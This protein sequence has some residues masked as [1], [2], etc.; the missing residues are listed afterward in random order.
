MK[1]YTKK[2]KYIRTTWSGKNND[3]MKLYVRIR[4]FDHNGKEQCASKHF[5]SNDYDSYKETMDAAIEW[6]DK[7]LVETRQ[8]IHTISSDTTIDNLWNDFHNVYSRAE[9][10]YKMY[11]YL[12]KN[13]IHDNFGYMAVKDVQPVDVTRSLNKCAEV[14]GDAHIGK[15]WALW[16]MLLNIPK[17]HRIYIDN[18]AE[19]AEVPKSK[20]VTKHTGTS[21]ATNET[22]FTLVD[23]LLNTNSYNKKIV[24]HAFMVMRLTGLR[25]EECFALDD[26]IFTEDKIYV[27]MALKLL[28]EGFGLG[29]LKNRTSERNVPISEECRYWLNSL[30]DL[31]DN[32][33]PFMSKK[34]KMFNIHSLSGNVAEW[35]EKIGVKC[36]LKTMRHMFSTDLLTLDPVTDLRTTAELM[37]HTAPSMSVF[38]ARS[39]DELKI[40]AVEKVGKLVH[41]DFK[42]SSK[43]VPKVSRK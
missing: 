24:A 3:I 14:A 33:Y 25:P 39:N 36:S 27:R 21:E 38:Y 11:S 30:H 40:K 35:Q 23:Y 5:T 17:L 16:K 41:E 34:G 8:G 6:R 1:K 42:K 37:G 26:K 7:T 22:L 15:L 13:Y 31:T 19:I 32:E 9:A 12:Y 20:I 2:E 29:P 43:K 28:P 18:V 4:Y 10:T